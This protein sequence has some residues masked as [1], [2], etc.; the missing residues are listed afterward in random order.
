MERKQV[1]AL[2]FGGPLDGAE[3]PVDTLNNRHPSRAIYPIPTPLPSL[4]ELMK[5]KP[6]TDA[7]VAT[8]RVLLLVEPHGRSWPVLVHESVNNDPATIAAI[9]SQ[10]GLIEGRKRH[11]PPRG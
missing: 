7:K 11:P 5:S 4:A 1:M 8:Y 3:L 9:A 10:A 6:P 2:A